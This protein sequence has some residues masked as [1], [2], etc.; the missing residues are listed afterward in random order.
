MSAARPTNCSGFMP[1]RWTL[2]W[3]CVCIALSATVSVPAPAAPVATFAAL[4]WRLVGPFRGGWSEMVAGI[5]DRPDRFY[6]G[7]AGGGVWR[8]DNAG[9]TWTPVFNTGPAAVGAIAIA[10]SDPATIYIGTGQPEPR[11]DVAGGAGVFRTTDGGTTWKALGLRDTRHI[12]RIFIDPA[13]PNIVVV[14]AL[15]HLFGPNA[16]R[17]V[18]RSADGGATWTHV[19][20]PGAQTGAVDLTA[21]PADARTMFAATWQAR[22]YPWQSYFTPI[23]G[24]GSGIYKSVD[25]GRSWNR[26]SGNGWPTGDLG[27]ISLA[28][29][30]IAGGLRVYAVISAAAAGGLYRSDDGGMHWVR[31][32]ADPS[33]TN[34]YASR[35][36]VAPDDANVVYLVGQSVRRCTNG[37]AACTII[38]GAPGGDDYHGVWINPLHP[39]HLATVSDQGTAVSV[40]GGRSWSS[41]YNQPTGQFYHLATDQRFPYTIYA[42]QQDSGTVAIRSRSDYGSIGYRDWHSVG[43]DERDY[44]IPDPA[45]P[46]IVYGSGLGGAVT[47][48][49]GRTGDVSAIGPDLEP[50][51]GRR[52]T[53][54][55]H[56]FVW[57]TPIAVSQRGPATLYL[58]GEVL[59]ASTDRGRHWSAISPDLTGKKPG[60][61]DCAARA[62]AIAAAKACGYGAIW[63]L[64]VSPRHA[65]EIW[66][67]TDDGLVQLSR[68][69]GRHWRN[70]TPRGI[71]AWA[72]IATIDVSALH[73]GVAYAAVDNQRQDDV[74]PYIYKTRDYG[75]TWQNATGN[76]PADHFVSVVRAD[77]VRAGLLY[78]GTETG[79]FASFDDGR[80]WTPLQQNLPLAWV[81]D[82]L[83]HGDDL[84]AATQ[85]RAIWVLDDIRPLRAL[86]S[87][88]ALRATR[89]FSPAPAIRVRPNNN[90]DTPL[91]SDEPAGENPPPGAIIDYTLAAPARDRVAIEIRDR[92]Q[93]LV[94][95]LTSDAAPSPHADVYFSSAW[96]QPA[97]PLSRAVGFHR[98]TWNLRYTRPPAIDSEYSIA[99]IAGRDTPVQPGGAFVLPGSYTVVLRVDGRTYRAPLLVRADPRRALS[100]AALVAS[101]RLSQRIGTCL[102]RADRGDVQS[103]AARD[104]LVGLL[105]KLRPVQP[106]PLR[107][108]V[109]GLLAKLTPAPRA[110]FASASALLTSIES[111]LEGSDAAPTAPQELAAAQAMVQIDRLWQH[112]THLRDHDLRRLDRRLRSAGMSPVVAAR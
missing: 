49:D 16:E 38:K 46:T 54:T 37:G 57:V 41:W 39:D 53:T 27:R 112:W 95:R 62:V 98:V 8:T 83:V 51:Y 78:A 77:P 75:T 66:A 43:G 86:P 81:R 48:F 105:A 24:P 28:A 61:R 1:Y 56:H 93:R 88:A 47:R 63:S 35:V 94:Q 106:S 29:T 7:A 6:F 12:G 15:G 34:Y 50:N 5:P 18:F 14:A 19:L 26:L 9:R 22:Q 111:N 96:L 65:G 110:A 31:V 2:L 3:S 71:P 103:A 45:D 100:R 67:G 102:A 97:V 4:Q 90:R 104:A 58:G 44:D 85:G 76:L 33:F 64:A 79:V 55:E 68:D 20:D 23:A 101:L 52:Q 13:N 40:D 89:L 82:L 10:P 108:D 69:S 87:A 91:P 92:E 30:R 59:F 42:G 73:D 80:R 109:G 60:A 36:S 74:A 21:D 25:G 70:V 32:N 84:I 99:A 107:R 17:G 11:Y 72:K